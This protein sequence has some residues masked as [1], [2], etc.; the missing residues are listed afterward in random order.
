MKCLRYLASFL[1]FFIFL[2]GVNVNR[3]YGLNFKPGLWRIT[4]VIKVKDKE[5]KKYT[6]TQCLTEKHIISKEFTSGVFPGPGKDC[7]ISVKKEG[8]RARWTVTCKEG[9][10]MEGNVFYQ[11]E[12]F[13][14]KL[15]LF[16]PGAPV[17]EEYMSG[18][19]IGDCKTK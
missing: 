5:N 1:I 19:R 13:E 18:E 15:R 9:G 11:G 14:G 17:V 8:D 7:K 4:L 16:F 3:S 6:F 10:K 2:A 12:R